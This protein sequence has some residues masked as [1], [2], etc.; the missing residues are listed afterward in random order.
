MQFTPVTALLGGITLGIC[1]LAKFAITG[2]IL[3]ISGALKGCVQ[4]DLSPW[5]LLF[6]AGMLLGAFAAKEAVPHAFD[7]LPPTFTVSGSVS[8][9]ALQHSVVS[10]GMMTACKPSMQLPAGIIIG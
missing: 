8:I 4:A 2:R 9:V 3:G 6:T 5:R 10:H 1:S 7:V